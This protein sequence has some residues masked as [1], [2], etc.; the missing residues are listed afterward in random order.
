MEH[1]LFFKMFEK[2][3]AI[4]LYWFAAQQQ[5]GTLRRQ[6]F[7]LFYVEFSAEVNELSLFLVIVLSA[8]N[9]KFDEW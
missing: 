9:D 6:K 2:T 4:F 5:I 8:I 1:A 3:Q 7:G